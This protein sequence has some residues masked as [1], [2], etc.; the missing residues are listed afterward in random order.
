MQFHVRQL[1]SALVH[2]LNFAHMHALR[3][4]SCAFFKH[5]NVVMD[6]GEEGVSIGFT[7]YLWLFLICLHGYT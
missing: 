5:V 7:V 2:A 1:I 4:L 3:L 6:K